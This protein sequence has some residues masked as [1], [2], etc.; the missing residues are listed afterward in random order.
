[1]VS[2][3]FFEGILFHVF[4]Q[5]VGSLLEM[6]ERRPGAPIIAQKLTESM[7]LRAAT[8]PLENSIVMKKMN[9]DSNG[10]I[11]SSCYVGP[12]IEGHKRT[13]IQS[14]SVFVPAPVDKNGPYAFAV[15]FLMGGVSA[16][17]S[18]TAAA[19]IERVKLLIQNQDEMI[20]AGRLQQP[21]S[22]IGNCFSRT[23]QDEGFM[24]LWRGNTANVIRYFPTQVC[25]ISAY[26]HSG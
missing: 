23:V 14:N 18:K 8:K 5:W 20:K 24:S 6:A 17:V 7:G 22:G 11:P 13:F 9:Y 19:P 3:D 12:R 26:I 21:Y 1:M 15:D 4:I 16:A 25:L 2:I 10:V